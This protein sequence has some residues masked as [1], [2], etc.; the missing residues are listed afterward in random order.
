M[1]L[2]L[3]MYAITTL[4][5]SKALLNQIQPFFLISIR[6]IVAG[7]LLLLVYGI[8]HKK[9]AVLP[10]K[11]I[12][13]F[14]QVILYAL[15]IPYFLRYW[16]FQHA[17]HPR[18]DLLYMSGP[19]ITYLL[20]ALFDIENMTPLKSISLLLGYC[21]LLLFF[22]NPLIAY[23][24]DQFAMADLAIIVSVASFTYGWIVIRKLIVNHNYNPILINGIC[25]L[26]AGISSLFLAAHYE[27][28]VITGNVFQCII[29]LA[30]L[31]SI[32]N[33]CAHTMYAFLV[34]KYSL[35]FL[36]L[37]SLTTPVFIRFRQVLWGTTEFSLLLIIGSLIIGL[38][39]TL[40][41]FAQRKQP[42]LGYLPK[43]APF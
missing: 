19:L 12:F 14:I 4:P 34:K 32:S 30:A 1:L 40:F 42:S 39:I 25:M 16:G 10:K 41:Y 29:L 9:S 33:L 36:Q 26:C 11:Q 17:N 21:G 6:M 27:T 35:T 38:S 20:T 43:R 5:L 22:G 28:F 13:L 2:I 18:A 7:I 24:K 15:L 23:G 37:C 31:I 8:M 3:F